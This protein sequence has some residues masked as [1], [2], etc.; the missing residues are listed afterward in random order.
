MTNK[1]PFRWNFAKA[2]SFSGMASEFKV[3]NEDSSDLDVMCSQTTH[4]KY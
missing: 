4:E 2:V 3:F 1:A